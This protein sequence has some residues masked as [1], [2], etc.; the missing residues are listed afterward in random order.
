MTKIFRDYD[1]AALERQYLPAHWPG[2]AVPPTIDRWVNKS[3][4]VHRRIDVVADV[5]YG[6]TD[7]QKLDL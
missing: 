6:D 1:A 7:R 5:A 2:V 3:D 4:A